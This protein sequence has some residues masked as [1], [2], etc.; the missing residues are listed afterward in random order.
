M[1]D[2]A[3]AHAHGGHHW[4]WS[5]A[6]MAAVF[7]TFLVLPLAFSAYFVYNNTLLTAV[8][9]GVG[10][11]LLIAGVAKWV[12]EGISHKNLVEGVASVGLPIFIVSEIFIFLS[13]FATYWA[14][15]LMADVWPP[16][17]TPVMPVG[18]PLIMTAIL[19]TS[20]VTIHIGE[21][22]LEHGDMGGFRT[23]LN[24]TLLLGFAF[25]GCTIYEYNHLFH[26]GFIPSTNAFSTV[27]F[28][29]TGFHASHVLVGLC[30]FI[31]VLIPA[32]SGK[33]NKTFVQC[34]SVYW[35]FVDIVWFFVVSQIYF[36]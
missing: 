16:A 1:S 10:A 7:G 31:A 8:F 28:T 13:L 6:P 14:M 21:E 4:E 17:N 9:A 29:V 19:V 15:R 26:I 27:F 32:M 23:W 34:V 5:W 20:S 22:K 3:S 2:S 12:A 11:P 25:L 35:H 24:L 18:L 33:T 36:W 30:A